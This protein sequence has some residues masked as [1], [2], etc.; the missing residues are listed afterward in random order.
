MWKKFVYIA[1]LVFFATL[2]EVSLLYVGKYKDLGFKL[3]F[4]PDLDVF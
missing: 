1:V 2:L 4:K 3:S